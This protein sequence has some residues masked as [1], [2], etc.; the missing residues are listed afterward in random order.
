V[1]QIP[2]FAAL[3]AAASAVLFP[4]DDLYGKVDLPIALLEA[5]AYGV[6][7]L[8]LEQGPLLDLRG[9]AELVGADDPS[10]WVSACARLVTESGRR[11]Q[12]SETGRVYLASRHSAG[13]VAAAYERIYA[14]LLSARHNSRSS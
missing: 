5:L 6:P 7:V 9:G 3:L 10:G 11:H 4:V 14:G 8:A 2:D 13:A 12:A 1:A